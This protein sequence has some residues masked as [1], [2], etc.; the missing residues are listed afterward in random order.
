MEAVCTPSLSP[1][2]TAPNHQDLTIQPLSDLAASLHPH[3]HLGWSQVTP[4]LTW[5]PIIT[6]SLGATGPQ[7]GPLHKPASMN[8]EIHR[9]D[10]QITVTHSYAL[11]GV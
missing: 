4:C 7:L 11:Q 5:T 9:P 8:F 10:N 1:P 3:H 6:S 2:H